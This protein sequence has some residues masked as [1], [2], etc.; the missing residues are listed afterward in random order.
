MRSINKENKKFFLTAGLCLL[1]I[2]LVFVYSV[3]YAPSHSAAPR[4]KNGVLDLYGIDYGTGE[5]IYLDGEWEFFWNTLLVTDYEENKKPDGMIQVPSYWTGWNPDSQSLPHQGYASYRLHLIN[6]P[7]EADILVSVPNLPSAYRVFINGQSV[8]ESGTLLKN[9]N[10]IE[11]EPEIRKYNNFY[12]R[13]SECD[14]VIETASRTYPGLCITPVLIEHDAF[15]RDAR[16][17]L[18]FSSLLLGIAI[19][20]IIFYTMDLILKPKSGYSVSI[21]ILMLL[22]LLKSV[23][24]ASIFSALAYWSPLPFDY[25]LLPFHIAGAAAWSILLC[26]A[27]GMSKGRQAQRSML[28]VGL[29]MLGVY[30]VAIAIGAF[31]HTSWWWLVTDLLLAPILFFRLLVPVL[32]DS[33]PPNPYFFPYYLGCMALYTGGFLGDMALAGVFPS[34]DSF[35][36]PFSL[37][38][39]A[40]AI[41]YM[42]GKR[43]NSIQNEALFVAEMRAKLQRAQT[44]LALHQI[45]PHFLYNA[46]LAIKV[47]CR[48]DPAKA[49]RAVYDFSTYL[50]GNMNSIES[51][52]PILFEEELQN[53]RAYLNIEQVRFGDRLRVEWDIQFCNFMVP[54]LTVQP[55]VENAVRHGVCQKV[56]GGFVSLK[57]YQKD[58]Y[59]WIEITDDGVG[60]DT[61][62]LQSASFGGIGIKNLRYRL[63]TLLHAE[64]DIQSEIGKWTK[65]VIKIPEQEAQLFDEDPDC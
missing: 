5:P 11:I 29:L 51:T 19:V 24:R 43:M 47:L 6:C 20:F 34:G 14:L 49:E 40:I 33:N 8:T 64:L 56:E 18:I 65:Q 25:A 12:L 3:W 7:P 9:L 53:I 26:S 17:N 27:P 57:S 63:E 54:P 36:Y 10:N 38:L 42:D 22:L 44:D 60:F 31:F 21:L 13:S 39:L 50:R 48:K 55:L 32:K 2:S 61:E 28:F 16:R 41:K 35:A 37:V 1:L 46:L 62:Q 4:V 52:E 45:Q 15:E 30:G 58:G 23:Y 59:V